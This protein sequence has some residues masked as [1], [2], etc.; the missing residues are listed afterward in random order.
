MVVWADIR[1]A[2]F[3]PLYALVAW[4]M[5]IG[6]WHD[7]IRRRFASIDKKGP[8]RTIS[9]GIAASGLEARLPG[10]GEE[11]ARELNANRLESYLQYLRDYRPGGWPVDYSLINEPALRDGLDAG[12]GVILWVGHFVFN[13][14]PLK[15]AL[16][17]AGY[18]VFHLSRPEHG[19]SS[20]RF[21]IRVLNP[22]RSRIESRYLAKR[23]IIERGA[24]QRAMR[25]A[26]RLLSK[27]RIV[28]ITAGHWEGRRVA[29][30]PIGN[31]VLPLSVGAPSLAHATGARLL[32]LFIVRD[33]VN[34]ESRFRTILGDPIDC[35]REQHRDQ[36]VRS[37]VADFALQL[38]SPVV[39]NPDQ[40]R[41]WKYL[42]AAELSDGRKVNQ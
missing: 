4:F 38:I 12:R 8:L 16:H 23:V 39:G 13:G 14:L 1:L 10:G 22:V 7:L 32:P 25:E 24:Q 15:K 34:G 6:R 31:A 33:L 3:L 2:A 9:K 21:G 28:S 11:I 26:H 19:F 42:A 37:A 35:D 17:A 41:G 29:F 18:E 30:A 27:G 5:P 20:S 36:V 40:W